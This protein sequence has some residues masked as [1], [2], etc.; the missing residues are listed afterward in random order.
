MKQ[1]PSN[2]KEY[3]VYEEMFENITDVSWS[4]NIAPFS[5]DIKDIAKYGR[6]HHADENIY[7]ESG[8]IRPFNRTLVM[9]LPIEVRTQ[10]GKCIPLEC[11]IWSRT[12]QDLINRNIVANIRSAK[13]ID[14]LDVN[15]EFC[16]GSEELSEYYFDDKEFYKKLKKYIIQFIKKSAIIEAV[17]VDNYCDGLDATLSYVE[18]KEPLVHQRE[19]TTRELCEALGMPKSF[20][21]SKDYRYTTDAI[22][23]GSY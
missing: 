21:L 9:N 4:K 11:K 13:S 15:F 12:I 8:A 17:V 5:T 20:V 7:L 22:V 16:F 14:L 18:S 3:E 1:S 10:E 23:L 2:E 19:K 6:M